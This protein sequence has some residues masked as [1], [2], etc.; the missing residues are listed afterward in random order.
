MS[1]KSFRRGAKVHRS[2]RGGGAS[3]G[4]LLY[5]C[6]SAT[7]AHICRDSALVCVHSAPRNKMQKNERRMSKGADVFFE[8]FF[9][10]SP[11]ASHA[12]NMRPSCRRTR[13][14]RRS[15]RR[16]GAHDDARRVHYA[17]TIKLHTGVFRLVMRPCVRVCV[18]FQTRA[19]NMRAAR[20]SSSRNISKC[21]RR[22]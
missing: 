5:L 19:I 7:R 13:E 4:N 10:P 12:I 18:C 15:P 21:S 17:A 14:K 22:R 1:N 8:R 20:F 11:G 3:S 9:F 16:H 2:A 6:A